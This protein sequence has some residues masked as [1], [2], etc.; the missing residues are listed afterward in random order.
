[1]KTLIL[2]P[3]LRLFAFTALLSSVLAVEEAAPSIAAEAG[4]V[5]RVAGPAPR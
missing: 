5:H 1:M 2:F 4:A 3:I